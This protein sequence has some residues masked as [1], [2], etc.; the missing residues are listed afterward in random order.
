MKENAIT[1]LEQELVTVLRKEYSFYQSLYVLLDKQRDLLK[2]DKDEH[3]LDLYSEIERCQRR[4]QASEQTIEGLKD[5]DPRMFKIASI[6]PEVKKLVSS[7]V[8]LVKKNVLLVE[9]NEEYLR[10]RHQ[11]IKKELD[12]LKNSRKILQYMSDSEPS[13]QFVDGRK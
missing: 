4:I 2:Y 1:V 12:E 11:R 10:E 7:I 6:S 9:S 13:A 8:T 5:R 3:L